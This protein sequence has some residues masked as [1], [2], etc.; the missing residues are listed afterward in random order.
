M[1]IGWTGGWHARDSGRDMVWGSDAF[2]GSL[3]FE[4][5]NRGEYGAMV[6]AALASPWLLERA[7]LFFRWAVMMLVRLASI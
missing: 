1:V 6:E 2:P 5:K 3:T 4:A 7:R